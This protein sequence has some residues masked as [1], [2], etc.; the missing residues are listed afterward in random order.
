MHHPRV[1]TAAGHCCYTAIVDDPTAGRWRR[2]AVRSLESVCADW[3]ILHKVDTD[4]QVSLIL[5]LKA[6]PFC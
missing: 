1:R 3:L 6:Q 2:F 4:D 5:R